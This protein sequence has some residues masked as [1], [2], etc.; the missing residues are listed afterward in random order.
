MTRGLFVPLQAN[1]FA[2]DRIVQCTPLVQLV[3]LRGLCIAKQAGTDGVVTYA[4]LERESGDIPDLNACVTELTKLKLWKQKS[5]RNTT[6][7]FTIAHWLAH[8]RSQE[9]IENYRTARAV[10]GKR[11]GRPPNPPKGGKGNPLEGGRVTLSE[12]GKGTKGT[13]NLETEKDGRQTEEREDRHRHR[14]SR[15][16]SREQLTGG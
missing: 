11:G 13:E 5:D 10:D 3:Y 16:D 2:D 7:T 6:A 14:R 4:Q 1:F 8:N 9:W 12:N 15:H